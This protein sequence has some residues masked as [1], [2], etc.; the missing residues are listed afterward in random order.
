MKGYV[1][2]IELWQLNKLPQKP[3]AFTGFQGLPW[4]AVFV[5]VRTKTLLAA[6]LSILQA[7]T[8]RDLKRRMNPTLY[9]PDNRENLI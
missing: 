2:F 6:P 1:T 5:F 3:K 8:D 7:T 4:Q 9:I